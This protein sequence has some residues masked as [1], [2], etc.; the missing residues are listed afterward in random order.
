M[1]HGPG[2]P[3]NPMGDTFPMGGEPPNFLGGGPNQPG[4]DQMMAAPRGGSPEFMS[5]GGGFNEPQ[6]M[7]NEGLVW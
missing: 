5:A 1:D 2:G 3:I 7:Q 6:N 4:P